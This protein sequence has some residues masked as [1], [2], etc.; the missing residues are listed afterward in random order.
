MATSSFGFGRPIAVVK[1][2][3]F[4]VKI[5]VHFEISKTFKHFPHGLNLNM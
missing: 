1:Q 4:W 2:Y 5:Y 3:L